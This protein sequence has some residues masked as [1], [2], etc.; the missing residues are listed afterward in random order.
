YLQSCIDILQCMSDTAEI[1]L[2]AN[3]DFFNLRG[4]IDQDHPVVETIRDAVRTG[5]KGI[6]R[7]LEAQ[8]VIERHRADHNLVATVGRN[9]LARLLAGDA[10]YSGQINYG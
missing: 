3:I 6:L 4:D 5:K 2:R 9:V 7:R 10:T 1:G 8:G